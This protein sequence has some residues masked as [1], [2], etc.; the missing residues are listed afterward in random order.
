[1]QEWG[2]Q[3]TRQPEADNTLPFPTPTGFYPK[4]TSPKSNQQAQ[5]DMIEE[6]LQVTRETRGSHAAWAGV[7]EQQRA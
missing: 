1:M 7:R 6:T 3:N 4:G 5:I 2:R